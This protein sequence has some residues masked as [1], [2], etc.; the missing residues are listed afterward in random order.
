MIEC[1]IGL[2]ILIPIMARGKTSAQ[3]EKEGGGRDRY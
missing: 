1:I 3:Y 2:C